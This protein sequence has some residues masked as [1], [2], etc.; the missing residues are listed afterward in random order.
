MKR[1]IKFF[2]INIML[3]VCACAA[4][5]CVAPYACD[6]LTA[7]EGKITGSWQPYSAIK[8]ASSKISLVITGDLA[9]TNTATQEASA[10]GESGN[11]SSE[12]AESAMNSI[13]SKDS[14]DDS[15]LTATPSDILELMEKAQETIESETIKGSTSEENYTGGGTIVSY[16]NTQVQNKI[17]TSFY[18]LDIE[19]LLEQQADLE[20]EDESLPTVLI[21]HSHTTECYTLLDVGYYTES[22]DLKTKDTARNMVRVGDEICEILESC[23]IGVV[24]DTEIHDSSYNEAYSSSRKSVI[25]YLEKY[26]TIEITIDVHRDDI[27]YSDLTKVKPTVTINGKKAAR[28]MIISGCEYGSVTNFPNWEYNL[29]FSLAVNEK[30]N[31][32]Y[33]NLMRPVLFSQRKYNMDLTKNSFLLEIG[34]SANT[35]EEA[36]YSA[37]LFAYQLA[38]LIKEEYTKNS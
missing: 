34:T 25:A 31:S 13:T 30:I 33:E 27:T 14:F 6:A 7:L 29:R 10:G 16:S 18:S 24:H 8:T 35:L 12:N 9:D 17:P 26:P 21:Y 37:R 38:Q 4:A 19:S 5:V 36:C 28:M 32:A 1:E 20:I 23:G 3:L 2:A 15:D 22:T 11:E